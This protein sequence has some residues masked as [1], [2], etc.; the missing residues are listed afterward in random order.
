M[1][2]LLHRAK[3]VVY[4]TSLFLI[5]SIL[6]AQET[7]KTKKVLPADLIVSIQGDLPI[8]ISAPHGGRMS[9][10]EVNDRKGGESISKFTTTIDTGTLELS[11]LLAVSLEKEFNAKPYLIAAKFTRKHLDVN[12]PEKDA[13]ESPFAK[14]I[15]DAYHDSI[16]NAVK[17]IK[18]KFGRGLLLD[19]HGQAKDS[20][21]IFRGT[22]KSKTVTHLIDRFGRPALTGPKSILGILQTSGYKVFPA[23][24]SKDPEEPG[25]SGGYI[26]QT[27]GSSNS[28]TI[29]AIQLELGSDFRNKYKRQ[30]F[31][32][33]LA[34]AVHA[35]AKEYL[36]LDKQSPK[37]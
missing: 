4:L 27:Y 37:K 28:G 35:F 26:V 12:R 1:L 7:A 9:I 30:M 8:I 20:K 29:D 25:Y 2:T 34:K 31:A 22:A 5:S 14:P 24:D 3:V 23:G 21:T 18:E 13:F 36:P 10:P 19:I 11:E 6:L 15:F 16:K 33:D 32:D 17:D